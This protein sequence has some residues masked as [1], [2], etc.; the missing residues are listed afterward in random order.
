MNDLMTF[1]VAP[2][3]DQQ[4]HS[5]LE[6]QEYR[7]R[8]L[9]SRDLGPDDESGQP[10]SDYISAFLIPTR[11]GWVKEKGGRVVNSCARRYMLDPEFLEGLRDVLTF[12]LRN[13]P[14]RRP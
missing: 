4:V 7:R 12:R 11:D 6:W 5:L 2:W 10:D 1:V 14:G 3:T 9:A 8:D 13:H